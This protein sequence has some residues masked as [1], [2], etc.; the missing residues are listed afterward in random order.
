M[1]ERKVAKPLTLREYIGVLG[2]RKPERAAKDSSP[3][4][5]REYVGVSS[6]PTL[7]DAISLFRGAKRFL[8][9]LRMN[10]K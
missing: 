9:G 7:D 8:S 1:T 6:V 10:N 4:T 2:G 5:L 3:L